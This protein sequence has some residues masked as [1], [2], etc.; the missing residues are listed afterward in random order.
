MDHAQGIALGARPGGRHRVLDR[1]GHRAVPGTAG[2]GGHLHD[3]AVERTV[4]ARAPPARRCPA[5]ARGW[6][7]PR[8]GCRAASASWAA[9]SA[10]PIE[11][12][13]L[14]STTTSSAPVASIA[15]R[16]WP[17]LGRRP[18][19]PSMTSAPASANS[20]TRP[21][22]AATTTSLRP[23][24]SARFSRAR[25]T[26]SAKWVTS[27]RRGRARPDAGLDRGTRRRR[28]G[29]ARSR[30]PRRRRRPGS[31]RAVPAA[32][33]SGGID[34]VVGVEQVH[35]LVRRPVLGEV[36]GRELAPPGS[37]DCRPAVWSSSARLP[38]I[39][40]SAA[41]ST[42]H[43]PRPPASTTPASREHGQLLRRA[44]QRLAGGVGGRVHDVAEPVV[45]RL[46]GLGGRLGGG[47]RDG[48]DRAL[49]RLCPPRRTPPRS[50]APSPRRTPRPSG[51]PAPAWPIRRSSAPTS[52]LRI[53][54]E[55]PRAPSSAPRE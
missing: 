23:R 53:T 25:A 8:R 30:G 11:S 41:S 3:V 17:V 12:A 47:P 36:T 4:R 19:P 46:G 13:S 48:Q 39:A 15:A 7:S 18:G 33:R 21:G 24:R 44:G 9:A 35:H 42:T 37:P 28:R 26:C 54:P 14:G 20:S 40:D 55:L 22:P 29:R 43:S 38:V 34:V 2:R 52:W 51:R 5:P 6:G 31:R 32:S 50:P 27:I 1:D 16:I 10:T 45:R 49:D